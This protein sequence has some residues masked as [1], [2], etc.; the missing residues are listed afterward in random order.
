MV[1]PDFPP[2][3]ACACVCVLMCVRVCARVN[4]RN[5]DTCARCQQGSTLSAGQV[6]ASH[7]RAAN[8]ASDA[9]AVD[10]VASVSV[11][12]SHARACVCAGNHISMCVSGLD[13][14]KC[15]CVHCQPTHVLTKT[16]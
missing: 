6:R 12:E 1:D 4:E 11:R 15:I 5:H 16:C 13:L 7:D 9:H 8:S 14:L 10:C 3:K 2:L